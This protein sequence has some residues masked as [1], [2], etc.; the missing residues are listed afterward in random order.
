MSIDTARRPTRSSVRVTATWLL[1]MNL[2]LATWFWGLVVVVATGA[3]LVINQFGEV[4]NSVLAFA[5]QGAIWFP[6]SVLIGV[7]AAYLPVHVAT[8]LTRRSLA[9][10]S[11]VAAASMAVVY[12]VVFTGL[13]IVERTVFDALGWRWRFL[14]GLSPENAGA[15]TLLVSS[16]MLFL[17]A[18]VSGLLVAICYQRGGGWWGTLTLPL[19]AG[20]IVLVSALFAQDAGPFSTSEWFGGERP[21]LFASA[22]TLLIVAVMGV[23]FD[24]L[25]RGA[26]VPS[27]TS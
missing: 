11:L 16:T 2:Y 17:V 3:L 26:S 12:G 24:R 8:G 10:G 13:L 9:L 14:E 27:R 6:F 18:Y 4:N 23:V 20:P 22:A 1:W 5:R 7:T 15:G 19:T 21:L 25:T